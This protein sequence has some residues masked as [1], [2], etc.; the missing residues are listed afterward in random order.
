MGLLDSFLGG[1]GGD[2]SAPAPDPT[3]ADPS[4]GLTNAQM[5]QL[6]EE[7]LNDREEIGE[8]DQL[9]GNKARG[10]DG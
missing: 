3:A 2:S 10:N 1:F 7:R 5:Q 9:R 8:N 4:S 6:R